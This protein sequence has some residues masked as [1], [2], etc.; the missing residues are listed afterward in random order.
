[1]PSILRFDHIYIVASGAL[2]HWFRT[3]SVQDTSGRNVKILQSTQMAQ[4][5]R[6]GLTLFCNLLN[7]SQHIYQDCRMILYNFQAKW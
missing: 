3:H 6:D 7:S 5:D 4:H 1:M 2:D